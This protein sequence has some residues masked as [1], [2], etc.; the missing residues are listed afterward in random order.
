MITAESHYLVL[1]LIFL[2][3]E[4]F[5]IN[6]SRGHKQRDSSWIKKTYQEFDWKSN[7]GSCLS[8]FAPVIRIRL[9]MRRE[10]CRVIVYGKL[11]TP[12]IYYM[13]EG[14]QIMNFVR[15]CFAFLSTQEFNKWREIFS[16]SWTYV[17]T[18]LFT[19]SCR[20]R[21]YRFFLLRFLCLANVF[22]AISIG[23]VHEMA[24]Q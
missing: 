9:Y 1:A 6:T 19:Q 4:V 22:K 18:F 21:E 24:I 3:D 20:W 2:L 5:I 11:L 10:M 16:M 7:F 23:Y 8:I 12:Q 17:C 13:Y 14:E 15:L